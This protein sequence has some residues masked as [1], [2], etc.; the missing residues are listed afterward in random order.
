MAHR[1]SAVNFRLVFVLRSEVLAKNVQTF[2]RASII[3]PKRQS[4]LEKVRLDLFEQPADFGD[5]FGPRS[6]ELFA[7]VAARH[8]CRLLSNIFRAHFGPNGHAP[9][10]VIPGFFTSAEVSVVN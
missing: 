9:L 10:D 3:L 1:E 6:T 5:E 2:D 8:E 4:L 7:R